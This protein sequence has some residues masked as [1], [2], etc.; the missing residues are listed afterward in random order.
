M[1]KST[2]RNTVITIGLGILFTLPVLAEG[3]TKGKL[4][5]PFS[6]QVSIQKTNI[7]TNSKTN[8]LVKFN[9]DSGSYLYKDSLSIKINPINGVKIGKFVLPKAEKK[10]DT[11][12]NSEKEIYHN[13]F[14]VLLPVEITNKVSPGKI[15]FSSVI[16]YQGCSKTVCF[17]P[18]ENTFKT[19]AVVK[20]K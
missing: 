15:S 18:Q 20:K 9:I 6:S 13:S 8:L 19:E 17:L 1:F 5:L 7:V 3:F 11:F 2:I 10:Y 4:K 16:G 14:S 12:S